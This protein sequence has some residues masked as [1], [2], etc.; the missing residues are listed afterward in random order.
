MA[1]T[2]AGGFAEPGTVATCGKGFTALDP[3]GGVGTGFTLAFAEGG[4]VTV[5]VTA[6]LVE[7]VAAATTPLPGGTTRVWFTKA[8]FAGCGNAVG[9]A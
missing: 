8:E 7:A 6:L 9:V 3:T 5:A 1:A 4:T 2:A